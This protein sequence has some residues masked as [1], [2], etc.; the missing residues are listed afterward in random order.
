MGL[1]GE[2]A[3]ISERHAN[4]LLRKNNFMCAA[5]DSVGTCF[6]SCAEYGALEMW[7]FTCYTWE[8]NDISILQR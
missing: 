4:A 6:V 2:A 5:G 7:H 3:N 1:M 8:Y